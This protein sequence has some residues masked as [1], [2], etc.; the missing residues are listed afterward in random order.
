MA[1]KTGVAIGDLTPTRSAVPVNIEALRPMIQALL[2]DRF[3]L[4]VHTEDRRIAAYTLIAAKPKLKK[5]VPTPVI[6]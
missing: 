6:S 2:V 3:K 4:K 5:A 1:V